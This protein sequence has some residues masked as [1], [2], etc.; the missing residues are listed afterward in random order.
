MRDVQFGRFENLILAGGEPVFD[1]PPTLIRV[2]R[3]GSEAV[4]R[5]PDLTD[6]TLTSS[7]V[8]L[9]NEFARIGDGIVNR[10]EFRHGL[11]VLIEA[12]MAA[13]QRSVSHI[14]KLERN[15]TDGA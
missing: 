6:W 7:V 8:E 15:V 9:L 14:A 5:S 12:L 13:K 1:P 3:I 2:A 11:P 10:L 4:D